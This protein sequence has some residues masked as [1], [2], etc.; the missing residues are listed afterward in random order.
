MSDDYRC[1]LPV[2]RLW[3]RDEFRSHHGYRVEACDEPVRRYGLVS[4]DDVREPALIPVDEQDEPLMAGRPRPS[5]Y[6]REGEWELKCDGGHVLLRA[7][8]ED[9]ETPLVPDLVDAA[10][11]YLDR[12]RLGGTE[13]D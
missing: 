2:V 3:S 1:P 12:L 10:L 5:V 8:N 9:R 7:D 13:G 4:S 6:V 11:A